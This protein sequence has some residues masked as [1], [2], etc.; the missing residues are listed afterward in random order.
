MLKVVLINRSDQQQ[1]QHAAALVRLKSTE[2]AGTLLTFLRCP[3]SPLIVGSGENATLQRSFPV[4]FANPRQSSIIDNIQP[5][6]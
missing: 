4:D 2:A 5:R 1:Q 6:Y 3:G